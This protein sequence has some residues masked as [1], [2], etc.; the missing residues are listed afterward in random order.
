MKEMKDNSNYS[1][2]PN[3]KKPVVITATVTHKPAPLPVSTTTGHIQDKPVLKPIACKKP[4]N[5]KNKS[6]P[7]VTFL[8]GDDN[9]KEF[10]GFQ[11]PLF[12]IANSPTCERLAMSELSLDDTYLGLLNIWDSI[13]VYNRVRT[14][15]YAC[16]SGSSD[17]EFKAC[18]SMVFMVFQ[19]EPISVTD[20]SSDLTFSDS[21][22]LY[23][24]G[25]DYDRSMSYKGDVQSLRGVV[26]IEKVPFKTCPASAILTT[27]D[28]LMNIQSILYS[29]NVRVIKGSLADHS[30]LSFMRCVGFRS[31]SEADGY[32]VTNIKN[33]YLNYM[34]WYGE[35]RDLIRPT[36]NKPPRIL[37]VP[38]KRS[39]Y[40]R[41]PRRAV[42][43]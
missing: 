36:S 42:I 38:P 30:L 6:K 7:L 2:K 29:F 21:Y 16:I 35:H 8:G 37:I 22:G 27:P 12:A 26:E 43:R 23:D 20:M 11:Q 10:A 13:H 25:V 3:K 34:I 41:S 24:T 33:D 18:K 4:C 5:K 14:A 1:A 9:N 28:Y 39:P 31:F 19:S 32:H 40:S 15:L 17:A